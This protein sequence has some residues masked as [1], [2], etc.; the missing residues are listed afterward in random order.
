MAD[1]RTDDRS[2]APDRS[3]KAT[4]S[5]GSST[6]KGQSSL[7]RGQERVAAA[8]AKARDSRSSRD[9]GSRSTNAGGG[10]TAGGAKPSRG[11][12]ARPTPRRVRRARL[13]LT[14]IDPWS[15]MKTA[16]LLSIAIGIV[17]VV[18]V[19]IVWSVLGAAGVWESINRAVADVAGDTGG[20]FQI[21]DY[22]GTSR[23]MGITMLLAVVD[24]FL[25][26]VVA[27]LGAFLY[28]LAAALLGGLEIVF[29]EE[30]R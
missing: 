16:F 12:G 1:R 7:S 24:V 21:E 29:A 9:E 4:G 5:G 28:N 22:L 30:E 27:T 15:V 10:S 20:D 13:R 6:P 26:T 8:V 3:G 17:T 18:A 23:I 11:S 25:I 14:H 2:V 19:G